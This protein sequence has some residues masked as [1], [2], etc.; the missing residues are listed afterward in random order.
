MSQLEVNTSLET[1]LDASVTNEHPSKCPRIQ[2][3]KMDVTSL[4]SDTGLCL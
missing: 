2:L 1:D 3:E 4:E